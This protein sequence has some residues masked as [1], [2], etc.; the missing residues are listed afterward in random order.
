MHAC[1]AERTASC[2]EKNPP[3]RWSSHRE[4][5][6]ST[7]MRRSLAFEP[8]CIAAG[9]LFRRPGSA[10]KAWPGGAGGGEVRG[11]G[12]GSSV[13]IN[14]DQRAFDRHRS[15]AINAHPWSSVARSSAAIKGHQGSSRIIIH[16]STVIIP[17]STV[18][19]PSSTVTIPSSTVIINHHHRPSSAPRE[20]AAGRA[21]R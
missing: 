20:V 10:R 19:I 4:V 17:S 7:A 8:A 12:L 18:I 1:R 13:S 9:R 2:A 21:G 16:S 11:V 5:V 3:S 15:M 14:G 6:E